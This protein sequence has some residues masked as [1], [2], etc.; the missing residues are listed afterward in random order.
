MQNGPYRARDV[1]ESMVNDCLLKTLILVAHFSYP[2][3]FC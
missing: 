1:R 2:I 3:E